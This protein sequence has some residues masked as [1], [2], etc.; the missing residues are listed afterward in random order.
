MTSNN[1]GALRLAAARPVLGTRG[2]T[3]RGLLGGQRGGWVG[4]AETC[5]GGPQDPLRGTQFDQGA[6]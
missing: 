1:F 4:G 3:I 5:K 2:G 6:G